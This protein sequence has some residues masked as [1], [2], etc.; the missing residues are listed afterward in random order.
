MLVTPTAFF[1]I[2]LHANLENKIIICARFSNLVSEMII[3]TRIVL[4]F[5]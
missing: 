3:S 1:N 5:K 4:P 2:N